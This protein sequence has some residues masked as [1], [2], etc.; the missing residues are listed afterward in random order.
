MSINTAE[1]RP[2]GRLRAKRPGESVQAK[3]SDIRLPH[4]LRSHT[5]KLGDGKIGIAPDLGRPDPPMAGIS[6]NTFHS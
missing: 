1:E 3:E 6:P 2:L 5:V 4:D